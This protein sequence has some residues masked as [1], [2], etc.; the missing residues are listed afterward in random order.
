MKKKQR[1]FIT[2]KLRA[3]CRSKIFL[4]NCVRYYSKKVFSLLNHLYIT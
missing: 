3:K 2:Y 1:L 4:L